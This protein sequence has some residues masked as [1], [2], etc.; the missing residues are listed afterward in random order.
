M[1]DA[2]AGAESDLMRRLDEAVSNVCGE[3]QRS[4]AYWCLNPDSSDTGGVLEDD[5]TTVR[6]DV[7]RALGPT[8]ATP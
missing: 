7:M 8:L 6:Y 3:S 2:V 4:Y 5:W 1:T